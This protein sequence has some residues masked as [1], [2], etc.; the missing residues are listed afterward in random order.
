MLEITRQSEWISVGKL[1][2]L[3][4]LTSR[5]FPGYDSAGVSSVN[6]HRA[7]NSENNGPD[8]VS[9]NT[10]PYA[11]ANAPP[12]E[13]PGRNYPVSSG[14]NLGYP[15]YPS[16]NNG[17][18]GSGYPPYP[19]NPG[20][21]SAP[22]SGTNLGYPPY[23]TQNRMP[24][25]GQVGVYQQP[26]PQ[27]GGYHPGNSASGYP[28]YPTNQQYP[29]HSNYPYQTRNYNSNAHYPRI[30]NSATRTNVAGATSVGLAWLVLAIVT[31]YLS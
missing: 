4:L 12:V 24:M 26:P 9:T 27:A 28:S 15:P 8:R 29:G 22:S 30:K 5:N 10:N 20:S 14:T 3:D 23:P 17:N 2:D 11:N 1:G 19:S 13:E 7:S 16:S 18:S 21:G 31:K 6:G 25:P